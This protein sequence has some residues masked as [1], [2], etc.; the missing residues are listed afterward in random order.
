MQ[1]N[2]LINHVKKVN[3]VL[4][5]VFFILGFIILIAGVLSNTLLKNIIPTILTIA[6]ASLV[7][8]LRRKNKNIAASIVIVSLAQLIPLLSASSDFALILS[9]LPLSI[10]ALYFN[11]WLFVAVGIVTNAIIVILQF[12]TPSANIMINLFSDVILI[13]ASIVLFFLTKEGA[14]LINNAAESEAQTRK[15][16]DDLQRTMDV[17]KTSTNTLNSDI[18][19]SNLNF[20]AVYEITASITAAT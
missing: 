16:L 6:S 9:L 14:S 3:K 17:I 1:E 18:S 13:L 15:L 2:S 19:K 8:F 7:L 11:K 12:R 5:C 4:N 10:T 20:E